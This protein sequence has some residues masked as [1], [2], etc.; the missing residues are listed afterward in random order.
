MNPN[1]VRGIR[2]QCVED[3]IPFFFKQWGEWAHTDHLTE[4]TYGELDKAINLSGLST[5]WFKV[6]KKKA[7]RELDGKIWEQYPELEA[8]AC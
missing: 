3:R 4:D 7:G 1:W 2:D 5:Q 6:G 8:V